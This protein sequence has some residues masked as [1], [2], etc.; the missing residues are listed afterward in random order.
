[1][2]S[3]CLSMLLVIAAFSLTGC[4][5]PLS[6][7]KA[8]VST[9][10]ASSLPISVSVIDARPYV[11]NTSKGE[12]F[13]GIQRVAF[14]I[15]TDFS[16]AKI[17]RSDPTN[18]WGYVDQS[19]SD[20]LAG[21]VSSALDKNGNSVSINKY[22]PGTSVTEVFRKKSSSEKALL[23]NVSQSKVD[24]GFGFSY[25]YEFR[26]NYSHG[27][28]TVEYPVAG[29]IKSMSEIMT[30]AEENNANIPDLLTLIYK[31]ILEKGLKQIELFERSI[32][33]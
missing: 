33:N 14:G 3:K 15:P 26:F 4:A 32:S 29:A 23:I 21:M 13:E 17:A 30:V 24:F 16:R 6:K 8:E 10:I 27:D 12:D 20:L 25:V 22:P 9:G 5:T 19:L 7:E 18:K 28:K 1:M 2:Y 11:I 31:D